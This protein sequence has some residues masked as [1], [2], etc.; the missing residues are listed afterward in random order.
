M[1]PVPIVEVF[2]PTIQ[3]EASLAGIRTMFVRTGYCDGPGN[4]KD[5]YPWCKWCDSLHA[6]D[7]K[8]KGNW[9]WMDEDE[10]YFKLRE[11]AP[12]CKVVSISGGNPA[13]H[14]MTDLVKLLRMHGYYINVE[15]QGTVYKKWL[16][17]CQSVTVSP[18]P[19]SA[20]GSVDLESLKSFF[21]K[22]GD[23]VTVDDPEYK[24]SPEVT[25]K[26]VVDPDQ[27]EDY[28][29]A[30]DLFKWADDA[31][32]WEIA[33]RYV[34]TLTY[35]T[36]TEEDLTRRW[37]RLIDRVSADATIGDIGV[38][39]QLHVLVWGHRLGV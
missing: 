36:D 10:I 12:Y 16:N 24:Q 39:P 2:G 26:I 23:L 9:T 17:Y 34:S 19:P 22:L 28:T 11:L 1:R 32:V 18:K 5:G 8:F 14:D 6:V 15:T 25:M 27:D 31:P 4:S 33:N 7:P 30:G 29:F 13:L 20:G 37:H 3:G 21:R 35:P 38:L